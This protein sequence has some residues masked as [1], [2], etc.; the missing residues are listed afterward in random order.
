MAFAFLAVPL[1]GEAAAACLSAKEQRQTIR[2][3]QALR[4]AQIGRILNG[5]VIRIQ[6][7]EARGALIYQVTVLTGNGQV[8]RHI[9]DARSGRVIR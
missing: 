6:L 5:E 7:C 4:P 3:G 9:V 1:A 8:K 2:Y